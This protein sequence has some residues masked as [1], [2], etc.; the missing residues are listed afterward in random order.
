M[1]IL[2]RMLMA[3]L[4]DRK[5]KKQRR[6]LSTV[7]AA[8]V[9]FMTTYSLILPAITLEEST[10]ETT[11]GIFLESADVSEADP[12]DDD[13]DPS[14]ELLLTD[15]AREESAPASDGWE[16]GLIE[17][18]DWEENGEL[19][20]IPDEP[21]LTDTGDEA[22]PDG[23][24]EEAT[25]A[26]EAE[27]DTQALSFTGGELTVRETLVSRQG[28]EDFLR[29]TYGAEARIPEDTVC[30]AQAFT[31]A[32]SGAAMGEESSLAEKYE[33]AAREKAARD[34]PEWDK[35]EVRMFDLQLAANGQ[36]VQA[37]NAL[38]A[39]LTLA[40]PIRSEA[41][42]LLHFEDNEAQEELRRIYAGET[43]GASSV[44]VHLPEVMH[45]AEFI[46]NAN[47]EVYKIR[48][49]SQTLNTF[50]VVIRGESEETE[51]RKE[52]TAHE[53]E[54]LTEAGTEAATETLTE[55]TAAGDETEEAAET[56]TGNV[57]AETEEATE[58]VTETASEATE[59][60]TEDTTESEESVGEGETESELEEQYPE[61]EFSDS[62][63]YTQ[64]K[65][66]APEG[67]F[68]E[69]TQ[70][71]LSDV[72]D[73]ETIA[74]ICDAALTENSLV[75]KVH[76][77]DISFRNS[78]NEEIEPLLPIRV[79]MTAEKCAEVGSSS[80]SSSVVHVDDSGNA[81]I[82]ENA[83]KVEAEAEDE[84]DA[85]K[86][87]DVET[88]AFEAKEFS[89]Y[90]LVYTVDFHYE[91]GD[92]N[93]PKSFD[94]SING[95]D[96]VTLSEM[97]EVLGI[98]DDTNYEN[99]DAFL[100]AVE[101]VTFSDESLV[102]VTKK[103]IGNDWTLQS[104]E[105]FS[106]PETLTIIMTDGE[107][108]VV[109]VTDAQTGEYADLEM[110]LKS[111][112][113]LK[114]TVLVDEDNQVGFN[115]STH[116]YTATV[117]LEFTLDQVDASH[118]KFDLTLGEDVII[119]D[120]FLNQN[121]SAYD[122][123]TNDESFEYK[124]VKGSD[125]R[126]H[127]QIEYMDSYL[128]EIAESGRSI[129]N[130]TL[131]V[132]MEVADNATKVGNDRRVNF[133]DSV[134]VI[135]PTGSVDLP[136]NVT[137]NADIYV[138]KSN[139]TYDK[140]ANQLKFTVTVNSNV[141]TNGKPVSLYDVMTV[142]DGVDLGISDIQVSSVKK[143][144][145]NWQWSDISSDNYLFAASTGS[146][147]LAVS[148]LPALAANEG[149]QIEYYYQLGDNVSSASE[150][151][152]N[153][154]NNVTA[155]TDDVEHKDEK[156]WSISKSGVSIGGKSGS[157]DASTGK[158]TWTI[159]V[160][161]NTNDKVSVT[162]DMLTSGSTV[163]II[164]KDGN[165]VSPEWDGNTLKLPAGGDNGNTF[166]ITYTTDAVSSDP[167]K[168]TN[169]SNTVHAGGKEATG[170]VQIP[171]ESNI[172][173][174]FISAAN[175]NGTP[176]LTWRVTIDVP[177]S[178]F[179]SGTVF[180]EELGFDQNYQHY[181]D[182][183]YFT[184]AQ[185]DALIA[186][187]KAVFGDALTDADITYV[188][189]SPIDTENGI[190]NRIPASLTFT[191]NKDWSDA[192]YNGKQI[193]IDYQTSANLAELNTDNNS[194]INTFSLGDLS[195]TATYSF[196]DRVV[197]KSD[198]GN[199]ADVTEKTVT[200]ENKKLH[201]VIQ[202]HLDKDTNKIT[203]TDTLPEGIEKITAV[204]M[205]KGENLYQM[206]SLYSD[207]NGVTWQVA[208]DWGYGVQPWKYSEYT[209]ITPSVTVDGNTVTMTADAGTSVPDYFKQDENFYF[210]IEVELK[211]N[212]F[213]ATGSVTKDYKNTVSVSLDDAP[214]GSDDQTQRT[215]LKTE[216]INKSGD[217]QSTW[218]TN[219]GAHEITYAIDINPT[220]GH[221]S[222]D[223]DGN[224]VN[225]VPITL[226]DSISYYRNVTDNAGNSHKVSMNL[227]EGSVKLQR[228]DSD[229]N[230]VDIPATEGWG[231][232]LNENATSTDPDRIKV[233]EINVFGI[234]DDTILRFVY[235]YNVEVEDLAKNATVNLGAIKN[236]AT[237]KG[238]FEESTSHTETKDWKKVSSSASTEST[239]ALTI[240]KVQ[241]GNYAITLP[242][243]YFKLEKFVP[244]PTGV[245]IDGTWEAVSA[246]GSNVDDPEETGLKVYKTNSNGKISISAD[247]ETLGEAGTQENGN[248]V[249]D[250][251]YRV[252]EYIAHDGYSLD[253]VSP[254]AGYFYFSDTQNKSDLAGLG[255]SG[256]SSHADNLLYE[257]DTLYMENTPISDTITASKRWNSSTTWPDDIIQI[258]LTL[259]KL[260]GTPITKEMTACTEEQTWTNPQILTA[261]NTS[262]KWEHLNIEALPMG[263]YK[264]V[265][266]GITYKTG[267]TQVSLTRE[268]KSGSDEV[269]W[270][271]ASD[272][273]VYETFGGKVTNG[274]ATI[275]NMGK[276]KLDVEK[277]W[278]TQDLPAGVKVVM[279]LTSRE[280][281]YATNGVIESVLPNFSGS[282]TEVADVEPIILDGTTDDIET[283][284]WNATFDSLNKFRYDEATNRLYEIEYSVSEK[285]MQGDRDITGRYLV[286]SERSS[287]G[288]K[289]TVN[290]APNVG[291]LAVQKVWQRKDGTNNAPD[292]VPEIV[293]S[294]ERYYIND[295]GTKVYDPT[296]ATENRG[297]TIDE[298]SKWDK[299]GDGT[300]EISWAMLFE[301]LQREVQVDVD[302]TLKTYDYYYVVKE[303]T[304]EGYTK[305]ISED[306][307]LTDGSTG[308]V[309]QITVTNVE[310]E[311][312][313]E[314]DNIDI[315][316][317]K[318]FT[319]ETG[320][321]TTIPEDASADFRLYRY[322]TI[323]RGDYDMINKTMTPNAAESEARD[324]DLEFNG[325]DKDAEW[326][327]HV[328]SN[329]ETENMYDVYTILKTGW[330]DLP[331]TETYIRGDSYVKYSYEYY[332]VERNATDAAHHSYTPMYIGGS[333][334]SPLTTDYIEEDAEGK[335]IAK[336]EIYN[337]PSDKTLTI[338]KYWVMLDQDAM[339]GVVVQLYRR[340]LDNG[341]N[342]TGEKELVTTFGTSTNG[343]FTTSAQDYV[344]ADGTAVTGYLLST[345][346]AWNISFSGLDDHYQYIV[347]ELGYLGKKSENGELKD[348]VIPLD[349]SA[350]LPRHYKYNS[351]QN[352]ELNLGNLS[353]ANL[354]NY[355]AEYGEGDGSQST[356][357]NN[358]GT[359]S[360][361]NVPQRAGYQ[362]HM[363]KKWYSFT[364]AGG[365]ADITSGY[366]GKGNGDKEASIIMQVYQRPYWALDT[367]G[368]QGQWASDEWTEYKKPIEISYS[369]MNAA[370]SGF[371]QS[372]TQH[373]G[374]VEIGLQESAGFAKF[375]YELND[376]GV[377][378]LVFYEYKF[379]EVGTKPGSDGRT[380]RTYS[381]AYEDEPENH[382]D[383]PNYYTGRGKIKIE[384]YETGLLKLIKDWK[385]KTDNKANKI[386]F[387]IVDHRGNDI[388]KEIYNSEYK[389]YYG[390]TEDQVAYIKELDKY[391]IVLDA[392]D[393]V[394]GNSNRWELMLSGLD[395]V[396]EITK[397]A[398]GN[399]V[400]KGEVT[401]TVE[402]VGAELK[403]G[404]IASVSDSNYPYTATY[405]RTVRFNDE[406]LVGNTA[407]GNED[408]S[409]MVAGGLQLDSARA[410]EESGSL[411]SV[412]VTNSDE[413]YTNLT[414]EKSWPGENYP[415]QTMKI[416]LQLQQRQQATDSNNNPLWRDDE[417]TIP[418]WASDWQAAEGTSLVS[419][420]LPRTGY[421][422]RNAWTY[423]WNG[424]PIQ[425]VTGNSGTENEQYNIL[426]YRVVETS[427]PD[428]TSSVLVA[429]DEDGNKIGVGEDVENFNGQTGSRENPI[430]Q[431]IENSVDEE[432]LHINKQWTN[433]Y[434]DNEDK[435]DT[436]AT[437]HT[438]KWPEGYEVGYKVVR[439]AYLISITDD[440]AQTVSR[441]DID[442]NESSYE[443]KSVS[444]GHNRLPIDEWTLDPLMTGTLSASQPYFDL[445][446]LPKGAII[447]TDDNPP[448][449]LFANYTYAVEYEYEVIETSITRNG[450]MEETNVTAKQEADASDVEKVNATITND[451]TNI[452]VQKIWSDG[453][454]NHTNE[455][456]T[457]QLY[458]S[459][460]R[461]EGVVPVENGK[462]T[463]YVSDMDDKGRTD[464][465]QGKIIVT[466][467]G[468]DGS[469]HEYELTAPSWSVTTGDLPETAAGTGNP[470]NYTVTVKS[471]DGSVI[472]SASV[473]E[474]AT[475]NVG[476][477]VT[478]S[479]SA[480]EPPKAFTLNFNLSWIKSW[481]SW[482]ATSAPTK[483]AASIDVKLKYNDTEET[484]TLNNANGWGA[485]L[486]KQL[487]VLDSSGNKIQYTLEAVGKQDTYIYEVNRNNSLTPTSF[488]G[489]DATDNSIM[490]SMTCVVQ[491]PVP[492]TGEIY[493]NGTIYSVG[494]GNTVTLNYSYQSWASG[495]NVEAKFGPYQ[496]YNY[497]ATETLNE[498]EGSV[499]FTLPSNGGSYLVLSGDTWK[500]A[501][502][503]L[504]YVTVNM[505]PARR[506]MKAAAPKKAPS[507][508]N[509][510]FTILGT[511]DK[512]PLD[513]V[514]IG[515][516]ITLYDGKWRYEWENLPTTDENGN[517][518]YY[519]VRET[520]A[521]LDSST[522]SVSTS[523]EYVKHDDTD[524]KRG[525]AV[526][527]VT[528]T[529]TREEPQYGSVKVTKAFVGLP[530]GTLPT[531]FKITN[532]VNGTEFTV[533]NKEGGSGT[534]A[535][536]YY[537]TID[538][539]TLGTEV[540]F[541]ESGY[542]VA[543]Y[544]VAT[545]PAADAT[546]KAV[547]ATATSA[548]T[549]GVASFSNT[550]TK[551]VRDFEFNKIWL[552]MTANLNSFTASDQQTWPTGAEITVEITRSNDTNFK[553]TYKLNGTAT[554]F[555]PETIA[556]TTLTKDQLKLVKTGDKDYNF[557]LESAVLE[558]VYV[559]GTE[560][561]AYVY[562]VKET[563]SPTD[564][565]A[566]HYGKKESDAWK[567]KQD[568]VNGAG[569]GEVIIN[570]ETGGYELPS[571]GGS[572]TW[573]YTILGSILIL[574]AGVMLWR[575]RRLI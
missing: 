170:T 357:K 541:T 184:D 13:V 42:L 66:Y 216:V 233:K 198:P 297:I 327:I 417:H 303:D 144:D 207:D 549:P 50:A 122:S 519:Y 566:K 215:T 413:P 134:T 3:V 90:A 136:D 562:T 119:P 420:T 377:Y 332:I 355:F 34:Y 317:H 179:K 551:K 187:M 421:S 204:A 185:K 319:T 490:A 20:D 6:V 312:K 109:Q 546:T 147:S 514:E 502:S 295:A 231:Y 138:S 254:E 348:V 480:V 142:P 57:Y 440:D 334:S 305:I 383:N 521:S 407:T 157:Y 363:E 310:N 472:E 489:D 504:S 151:D 408:G 86:L 78:R 227:K 269:V 234:P 322:V 113:S 515:T 565:A 108:F 561:K 522:T 76:A 168:A 330:N 477:N 188:A 366:T 72:E 455:T 195:K 571:T 132:D 543:G 52:E 287:D 238:T 547:Q 29:L 385:L 12:A 359:F 97:V 572:G 574:G 15:D 320:V 434:A 153:G 548:T 452:E 39:E 524:A 135:V 59:E 447:K 14:G 520:S 106:T 126:Y 128:T 497:S 380:Y 569:N 386:F 206:A 191:L 236:T 401:Y 304:V 212:E 411:T 166:T 172:S 526:V 454:E 518:I 267:E 456:V 232:T 433:L 501:S 137:E 438:I 558:A 485:S 288:L 349:S 528:N 523:Y 1:D 211:D 393:A 99:I 95:G 145:S 281:L 280:R 505:A 459:S 463:I 313:H 442:G 93:E 486:D 224:P 270:K 300:A 559:D 315:K 293:I 530:D 246:I 155:S 466:V 375:G 557:K 261:S 376:Q 346:N 527:K 294:L 387:T 328:D 360:I 77:V 374:W 396:E 45:D 228:K 235:T 272:E 105:P 38:H 230:W 405:Y 229:G 333:E 345:E 130:N 110:H 544:A 436:W 33:Q 4:K 47:G 64:V 218:N 36:T 301:N 40:Q 291:Q 117:K 470:I 343:V 27:E 21:V 500:I 182:M 378:E 491:A 201:W 133:T 575:R 112:T 152:A 462:I 120:S 356:T 173:K 180:K 398:S 81:T 31:P 239:G 141:G 88:I 510:S 115:Q 336:S 453:S 475:V 85:D 161:N 268:V 533:S 53:T 302:G 94:F 5:H 292:T 389:E 469:S 552:P 567:Y 171:A 210:Y 540:T 263:Q 160:T 245:D 189:A 73:D 186:K 437:D 494:A 441:T 403:N 192:N 286:T 435:S 493:F 44:E 306:M 125:G 430:K 479:A 384:N 150:F 409:S 364:G 257:A 382:E 482:D 175:V 82:V 259:T 509:K 129:E 139:G 550:Y 250:Q 308:Q 248:F 104:L 226:T 67:A 74:A 473:T 131:N 525:Y 18:A 381:D 197:K 121:F 370:G 390:V 17:D 314:V 415:D 555:E 353:V 416:V 273:V 532:S 225:D 512:T 101:D 412:R 465:D 536:P 388:A 176:V 443:Q 488:T 483:D 507:V 391:V 54:P 32:S 325:A 11:D 431:G 284:A 23:I 190:Y 98:L 100:E 432:T 162:D 428:W 58:A 468:D 68:P 247:P 277:K 568:M 474:N 264:I 352:Y 397:D 243:T 217:S 379:V 37:E 43:A 274:S 347:K 258:E 426:W 406:Q 83:Q 87:E 165:A 573:A 338:R 337:I 340:P 484:L 114:A 116:H 429:Y 424:L 299:N 427:A 517:P 439:K 285:V 35:I 331:I 418:Q 177:S 196:K 60:A 282:Y 219:N 249:K 368:H 223:Q 373:N 118:K 467:T 48:F 450:V 350:F 513:A 539:L 9:V 329:T 342:P 22:T 296:F 80:V 422:G 237:I 75:Q 554:E 266:T 16:D 63:Q 425:K 265:E 169:I 89:V 311:E 511:G 481:D 62:T 46:R 365:F 354:E 96:S 275:V 341:N 69:G 395:I 535:D 307:K 123:V 103:L 56:E 276:T 392:S 318:I 414:V 240:V 91:N 538:N 461:P 458:K 495:Y 339:P 84:K 24:L 516:P 262:A 367:Y 255:Y 553:L 444:Y 2:I 19:A 471:V 278:G 209:A 260:D 531:D 449:G 102:K 492:E 445:E 7:L 564:Y 159:T 199:E 460:Q 71:L 464:M 79:E 369:S 496:W 323:E 167:T 457:V 283:V 402:E 529:T 194:Y 200:Q 154:K 205:G 326:T 41:L 178:G 149:Y 448:A 570:Q 372:E 362:L 55:S 419:V 371:P 164:D 400:G 111:G 65:V 202:V 446:D 26:A 358:Y 107:K 476:E 163:T 143:H 321:P 508:S 503:S 361:G 534:A 252:R 563:N 221:L 203:V 298:S 214:Y 556:G 335:K 148:N 208:P 30:S 290:N 404:S 289:V 410:Y 61:V 183:A 174:R 344:M 127:I 241:K 92:E 25:D 309:A 244:A 394:S 181:E 279:T 478:L 399:Y 146:N 256:A 351:E 220:G 487:N 537:W 251:L 28:G 193:V 499:T 560:E 70:M 156:N 253:N 271:D 213:P 222:Y 8:V 10:A 158:I 316:L 542:D 324:K 423:K 506:T 451:L 51:N 242:G 545:V 49:A 498:N 124:F 140:A